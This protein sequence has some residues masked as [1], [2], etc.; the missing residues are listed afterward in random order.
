MVQQL[1]ANFFPRRELQAL[2]LKA[3]ELRKQ[4][5]DPDLQRGLRRLIDGAAFLEGV[6]AERTPTTH[7]TDRA[8]ANPSG[9]TYKWVGGS[10]S[11][12][13][14]CGEVVRV[15]YAQQVLITGDPKNF[16]GTSRYR[17]TLGGDEDNPGEEHISD[18][19][20]ALR[21]EVEYYLNRHKTLIN[22]AARENFMATLFSTEVATP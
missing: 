18:S 19:L 4:A 21:A 8:L 11:F 6:L 14:D 22:E 3:D 13:G 20:P 10:F 9:W 7:P 15:G 2:C 12:H 1:P 17:I 5:V 16:I